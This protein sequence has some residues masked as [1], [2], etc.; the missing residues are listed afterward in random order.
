LV[1]HYYMNTIKEVILSAGSINSP[2][3]LMLSGIGPK[4]ELEKFQIPVIQNLKVGE[5]MQDHVALGGL[6]FVIDEPISLR[7][8]RVSGIRT[9]MNYAAMGDGPLTVLGGVEGLAFVNTK[10]ANK[11]EDFPDIEFHFVSGSTN[12]DASQ[13]SKVH[14]L[15]H[16]FYNRTFGPI[17]AEDTWSVIPMLLRPRSRGVVKLKSKNPFH[18]PLIYANYFQDNHDMKVLVEGVKIAMA[19]SKTRPFRKLKSYFNG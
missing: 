14:G 11:S 6:T 2:Q 18:Y 7:L 12:S 5:N 15:T 10:Y 3:I 17:T 16:E 13:L 8:E 4:E 9:V 1:H 19:L